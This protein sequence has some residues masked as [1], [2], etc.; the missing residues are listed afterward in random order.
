[1]VQYDMV[2]RGLEPRTFRL[3]AVRINQ[4]NYETLKVILSCKCNMLQMLE[5]VN[6]SSP[7]KPIDRPGGWL[8][9]LTGFHT[10]DVADVLE[11]R[12]DVQT[13][14][15]YLNGA[16]FGACGGFNSWS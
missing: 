10:L 4:L 9:G 13:F 12:V 5:C 7:H 6:I 11:H 16:D 2:P 3:L 1:M 14:R 15:I 8:A